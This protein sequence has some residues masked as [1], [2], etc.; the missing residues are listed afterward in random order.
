MLLHRGA[1]LEESEYLGEAVKSLVH[2]LLSRLLDE[3]LE[4]VAQ[5]VH[6]TQKTL[7][8]GTVSRNF[9]LLVFF[10]NQFSPSPRVF[11]K[12]RFEFFENSRIYS[13]VKVHNRYQR[14]R[15]QTMGTIIKLLTT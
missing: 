13:Q 11:H 8:K 5:L 15:W 9:L 6:F 3:V 1:F 2:L 10:M 7:L 4:V 14:H 12:H